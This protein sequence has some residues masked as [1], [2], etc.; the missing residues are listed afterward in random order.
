M[1]NDH[2][3]WAP[4]WGRQWVHPFDQSDAYRDMIIRSAS[5]STLLRRMARTAGYWRHEAKEARERA[6]DT[7]YWVECW[8][9][10]ANG[11]LWT[12]GER[13]RERDRAERAE[14]RVRELESQ[15]EEHGLYEEYGDG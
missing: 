2:D 13:D 6:K 9:T 4:G 1:T 10:A 15:A 8:K 11:V 5:L 7:D 12:I 3:D 14:S